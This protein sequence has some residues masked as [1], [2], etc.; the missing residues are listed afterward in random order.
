MSNILEIQPILKCENVTRTFTKN[1]QQLHVLKGVNLEVF[2]GELI[3]IKGRSGEGKTVLQW[4]LSGID[5]PTTGEVFLEDVKFSAFSKEEI[6]GIRREKIGLV[7]QNFNLIQSWTA[8][9]NVE[10]AL[11]NSELSHIGRTEK[12]RNA[13]TE[14]GLGNRL[15]N[16]PMELSVGQ[17]QRVALARALINDPL[18]IIAD[19]HREC[20]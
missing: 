13:L 6:S 16:L 10:A 15:H 12:A 19:T 7:F 8:L 14:L 11:I 17:Q 1:N 4:I 3:V 20:G 5:M 18:L 2:P 9:E